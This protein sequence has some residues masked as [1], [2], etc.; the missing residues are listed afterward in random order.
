MT[1]IPVAALGNRACESEYSCHYAM[2]WQMRDRKIPP[3]A[4]VPPACWEPHGLSAAFGGE[5][6]PVHA[7]Y[8]EAH[9][10]DREPALS[11]L[12]DGLGMDSRVESFSTRICSVAALALGCLVAIF[13]L[14]SEVAEVKTTSLLIAQA[15]TLL[16]VPLCA[17]L[18]LILTSPRGVMKNLKNSALSIVLGTVGFLI[19]LALAYNR[20]EGLIGT[21]KGWLQAG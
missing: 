17:A 19:L 16:A 4:G 14:E 21:V 11:V 5:P 7:G 20:L 9:D 6:A 2:N 8:Q 15:S 12:A 10:R 1:A 13:T 18:L 3:S